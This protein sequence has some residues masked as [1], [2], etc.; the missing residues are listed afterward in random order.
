[1][2]TVYS[3]HLVKKPENKDYLRIKTKFSDLISDAADLS[4]L[5][6]IRV[7]GQKLGVPSNISLP[8]QKESYIITI[9]I[10]KPIYRMYFN[11]PE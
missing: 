8:K 1:M 3:D 2:T 7:A 10:D 6:E 11:R 4:S 9:T 5:D